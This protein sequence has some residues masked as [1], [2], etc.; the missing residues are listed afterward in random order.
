M[1]IGQGSE[2]SKDK[3]EPAYTAMSGHC[4][5]HDNLQRILVSISMQILLSKSRPVLLLVNFNLELH[6][7]EFSRRCNFH[8]NEVDKPPQLAH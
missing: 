7:E 3:L 5:N 4:T 8:L 6:R 2:K 1:E